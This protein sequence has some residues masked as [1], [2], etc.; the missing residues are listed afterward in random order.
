[1]AKVGRPK[2]EIG[3]EEFQKLCALQCTL[4]EMAG[5]F[6]CSED[7]IQRWCK[8]TYKQNFALVFKR[9]SAAG[10]LSLRRYQFKLAEK[11][12]AMAIFLGKNYLGQTDYIEHVDETALSRLDEILG[13]VKQNAAAAKKPDESPKDGAE[14]SET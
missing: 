3:K 4:E 11:N 1:M 6:D 5:F 10:K 13:S 8:R 12:T 7:T 14:N 2:K 9:H